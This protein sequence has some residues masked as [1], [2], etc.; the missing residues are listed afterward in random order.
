MVLWID[1]YKPKN[2][3]DLLG[4]KDEIKQINEW[5]KKG[6]ERGLI[7]SGDYG[8]GKS[9]IINIILKEHNYE[10]IEYNMTYYKNKNDIKE[11][12][13]GCTNYKHIN[14]NKKKCLVIEEVDNMD[15]NI[16]TKIQEKIKEKGW[17][18]ILICKE[19]SKKEKEMKNLCKIIKIKKPEY[20]ELKKLTKKIIKNENLKLN[21]EIINYCIEK[22]E[23]NIQNL[24]YYLEEINNYKKV[25]KIKITE[26]R[27]IIENIC[28]RDKD[29]HLNKIIEKIFFNNKEI[30]I[31]EGLRYNNMEKTLSSLL[32][33]ENYIAWINKYGIN[34]EEN[35]DSMI[36]IIDNISY[37]DIIDNNIYSNQNWELNEIFGIHNICNTVETLKGLKINENINKKYLFKFTS[38]ISK[39]STKSSRTKFIKK[40]IN[41]TKKE[42]LL[43]ELP[44]LTIIILRDLIFEKIKNQDENE[45]KEAIEYIIEYNIEIDDLDSL[46][47]IYNFEE[48][49]KYTM[50]MKQKIKKLYNDRLIQID[51]EKKKRITERLI[52]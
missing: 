28:K 5:L 46:F 17:P 22:S 8:T 52:N 1:K 49:Y 26:C 15:R 9:C 21:D 10:I 24:I 16:I 2:I 4:N 35:L 14:K 7:I 33:H 30:D 38:M 19:N 23:S 41:N 6:K 50:K 51:N 27:N 44:N 20:E 32:I 13:K 31:D 12:I 39:N 42:K 45:M 37:S 11:F 43:E 34:E 18:I 48:K 3:N 47:K 36:D 25:E 40:L 29:L